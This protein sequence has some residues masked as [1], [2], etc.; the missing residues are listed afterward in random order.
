[1]TEPHVLA[2]RLRQIADRLEADDTFGGAL[3]A[4]DLREAADV[5]DATP[6]DPERE[7]RRRI[8]VMIEEAVKRGPRGKP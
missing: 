3:A 5:I 1:M 6:V 2:G 4:R 8:G 7:H